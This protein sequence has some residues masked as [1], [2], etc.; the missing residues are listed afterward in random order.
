MHTSLDLSCGAGGAST[1]A[2]KHCTPPRTRLRAGE[3]ETKSVYIGKLA[4]LKKVGGPIEARASE[5]AAR[6]GG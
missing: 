5:E 2:N 4:E 1:N 6:P 3:D